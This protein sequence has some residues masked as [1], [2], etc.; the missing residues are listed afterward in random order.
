[1][2][3]IGN[4]TVTNKDGELEYSEM[5][6]LDAGTVTIIDGVGAS[7]V[8]S[9]VDAQDIADTVAQNER[10]A[11]LDELPRNVDDL[12]LESAENVGALFKD[13]LVARQVIGSLIAAGVT[14]QADIDAAAASADVYIEGLKSDK[15]QRKQKLAERQG[16]A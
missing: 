9:A 7:P 3:I 10:Q 5:Y 15:A 1:M 8:T 13:S 11:L 16:K 2:A 4:R 12:A 6:D 14:T